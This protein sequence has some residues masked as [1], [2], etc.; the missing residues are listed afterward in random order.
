MTS[1]VRR[2]PQFTKNAAKRIA[3]E[4]Y[5]LSLTAVSLPS[6]RDQN[7][8]LRSPPSP[9]GR[10]SERSGEHF[11]MKIANA[12]ETYEILDLQNQVIQFLADRGIELEF[13][14]VVRT[15]MGK[16]IATVKSENADEHFV[17]LFTWLDGVCLAKVKPHGRE[18]LSSLGRALAQMDAVLAEFSH[19]TAHRSFHWDLRNAAMARSHVELLPDSRRP[20]VERFFA[21]WEKIH[22]NSLRFSVVHNDANDYNVLV[23]PPGTPKRQIIAILDYG[24]M[25]YTATICE[26]AIALAYVMLD[27]PDPIGAAAQVVTAYNETYPLT[28]PEI[29]VLYTLA[30]TRLCCSVCFAAKQSRAAPNNKYLNI[31]NAPVWALLE[32]LATIPFDWPRQVFRY[33]CGLPLSKEQSSLPRR[34]QE[35]LL[36]SRKKHLGLSLSLSYCSPLHIV[37]GSR[38]YLYDADGRRYLDCVNNVAHVGHSHP[39]VVRAASEQMAILNTN[40]RYLHQHLIEYSERLTAML[41]D[42][43]SVVYLVCSGSEANELA[44]RLARTHTGGT[45]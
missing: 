40:T 20:I 29:D 19:P 38:Q 1:V 35:E 34:K 21:D 45:K 41:P 42:P 24:D 32:K 17:R 36:V 6:E 15:K 14:H 44:L 4:V 43:L 7:F 13:P 3:A 22:W 9:S 25:V 33:A 18:L 11:V 10:G 2:A 5:G 39:Y 28:E 31:S 16:E 23:S 30:M 26:L 37:C 8:L 12:E 27:K